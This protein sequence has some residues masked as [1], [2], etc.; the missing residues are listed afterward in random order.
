MVIFNWLFSIIFF[1]SFF[2]VHSDNITE[3]KDECR[4]LFNI[5][6]ESLGELD[7]CTIGNAVP[8]GMCDACI[9]QYVK[10]VQS[11]HN[12]T[13]VSDPKSVRERCIDR[14][15]NQDALNIVWQQYQSAKNL[16]NNADCSNCFV[17]QC[18]ADKIV[19]VNKVKE[20]C[21]QN[22]EIIN[23]KN[24]TSILNDC[25]REG[26][27]HRVDVCK[28]C[29]T[30]FNSLEETYKNLPGS[31]N[32]ICFEAID[33]FNRTSS[34]WYNDRKC[35]KPVVPMHLS[36]TLEVVLILIGILVLSAMGYGG[37]YAFTIYRQQG[38]YVEQLDSDSGEV[39]PPINP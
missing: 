28:E 1:A 11:F 9:G 17:E 2:C 24:R 36:V 22:V 7:V 26:D 15:M 30:K 10:A 39:T 38:N 32:Q 37:F 5:L 23:F 21:K 35:L 25:L 33:Q 20:L 8:V 27:I 3:A 31:P 18:D 12:L 29:L 19:D 14:F 6:K 4:K 16:W 34:T 13:N